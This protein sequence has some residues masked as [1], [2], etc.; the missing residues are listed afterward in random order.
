[1]EVAESSTAYD[2]TVKLGHKTE[3]TGISPRSLLF[4]R[5][6]SIPTAHPSSCRTFIP[7]G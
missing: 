6:D 5:L 4:G 3:A 7:L 1:M 2:A